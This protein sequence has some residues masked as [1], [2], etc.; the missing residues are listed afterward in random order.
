MRPGRSLLVTAILVAGVAIAGCTSSGATTTS[1]APATPGP[2]TTAAPKASVAGTSSPTAAPITAG[3]GAAACAGTRSWGAG[4]KQRAPYSGAPLYLVRAGRHDCYD[5]VMFDVNAPDAVGYHVQY[6]SMVRSDGAGTPVPV[7]GGA[8]L[9]VVV[10]APALG[11]DN[12]GHQPGAVLARP[13]Q[14]FYSAAQ[15]AGWRTLRQVRYAGTFEG[16]T[17]IAVGVRTRVPFRVFTLLNARDQVMRV[18]LDV[19]H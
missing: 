1:A 4:V 6:V 10:H 19:A 16:Q 9:E 2:T 17:T 15:L 14:S 3:G 12:Q 18:V 7:A 11:A 8:A 13:G 5:R